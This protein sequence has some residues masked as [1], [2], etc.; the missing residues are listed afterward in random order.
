MIVYGILHCTCRSTPRWM[1][2]SQI[3]P[4]IAHISFSIL[5]AHI[6]QTR[7]SQIYSP[8]NLWFPQI[9]PL[10]AHI[11]LL[12]WELIFGRPG[13]CRSIPYK[14]LISQMFVYWI[15]HCTC[16]SPYI[17]PADVPLKCWFQRWL[18]MAS[19]T[20]AA[21][22][23]TLHLQICHLPRQMAISQFPGLTAHISFLP[24]KLIFGRPS[25]GRS[26]PLSNG[27][28]TD[29]CFD[30]SYFIPM[31]RVHIW[32][33]RCLQIYLPSLVLVVGA[34]INT[35]I[36]TKFVYTTYSKWSWV[37]KLYDKTKSF[38]IGIIWV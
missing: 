38:S 21:D 12:L 20:A 10:T 36:T 28:F 19:H 25:V 13:V 5:R 7:C 6:L 27:N 17:T 32:Q 2:I 30:S 11:S 23:L 15:L 18:C 34:F 37:G 9:P 31:L 3:P 35:I 26:T 33:T 29:S 22:H 1:A 24:W 16:R 4:L 14:M 8:S